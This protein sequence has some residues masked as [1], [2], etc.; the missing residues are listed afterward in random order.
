[1]GNIIPFDGSVADGEAMVNQ[2]SLT[3]ESVP[4]RKTMGASVFAE[5]VVE[6]GELI[7]SVADTIVFDKT[8]TLTKAKPIVADDLFQIV[9]LK[10]I[11][12]ALM[13]RIRKNYRV[14]VGFNSM[15]IVLGVGGVIQPTTSALLHNAS[16][17]VIGLKSMQHLI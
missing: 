16:T 7:I 5:T 3:G 15:L 13:K 6:E 17:L 4:V 8:G 1:M 11:S 2:A 10:V 14:I 12:D 9:T